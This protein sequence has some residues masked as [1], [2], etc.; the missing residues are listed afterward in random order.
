MTKSL[1]ELEQD[2]ANHLNRAKYLEGAIKD[3]EELAKTLKDEHRRIMGG[4]YSK[5]G[6]IKQTEQEIHKAKLLLEDAK[7]AHPV[8]KGHEGWE[9]DYVVTRVTPKCLYL[10]RVGQEHEDRVR[11]SHSASDNY[12]VTHRGLDVEATIKRVQ[13]LKNNGR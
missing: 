13:E 2:L 12:W 8:L 10:R 5:W 7:L 4:G 1:Q 9:E 6:L 11:T 3:A